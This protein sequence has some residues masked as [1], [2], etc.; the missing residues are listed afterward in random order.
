MEFSNK[1]R[2]VGGGGRRGI[3]QAT[4]NLVRVNYKYSS[5]MRSACDCM[6]SG[7]CVVVRGY[8]NEKGG[9]TE[10]RRVVTR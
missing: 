2:R 4:A 7:L 3:V 1:G 8:G 6:G 9:E 5:N 10:L